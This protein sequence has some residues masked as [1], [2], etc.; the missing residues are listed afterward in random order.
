MCAVKHVN[1][2]SYTAMDI[3]SLS[4]PTLPNLIYTYDEVGHVHD[5]RKK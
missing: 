3:F 5:I 4:N 1:P 2:T